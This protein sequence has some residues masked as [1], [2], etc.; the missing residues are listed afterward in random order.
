VPGITN[1]LERERIPYFLISGHHSSESV[2]QSFLTVLKAIAVFKHIWGSKIGM[3]GHLYPGMLDFGYDPTMMY[4]TFGVATI[5]ILERFLLETFEKV[6]EK[7]V[8]SLT[9]KLRQKYKISGDFEGKEFTNSMRVALAMKHIVKDKGLDAVTVYCQSLWQHPEIGVVPC[10]GMS[11]LMQEGIFC[12]CEG[13][14]PTALSGMILE[15]LS[16]KSIFTE[17]WSNDFDNDQFMMG[18]SGTMN[19][20]LFEENTKSV[21]L[22]RHPWWTGCCGRGASLE[23]KMSPGEATLLNISPVQGSHWRMIVTT[24]DVLEKDPV[25]LGAPNFFVKLRK[26]IPQFLEELV[27]AGAAHHFA[28]A[29]G[30]WT[31]HLKS[32]ARILKVEYTYI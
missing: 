2:K 18:H 9:E 14:I 8:A 28:M 27:R 6:D 22:S 32:L 15:K 4:T 21:K 31:G 23:V 24:V 19:L 26:P 17:I 29:Y 11:L 13:D 10:V 20:G 16:G 3:F 25:P 7:D 12:S 30:D 1:L 5:P